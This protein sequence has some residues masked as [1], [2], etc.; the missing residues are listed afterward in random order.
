MVGMMV[1]VGVSGIA[2]FALY[3]AIAQVTNVQRVI[4]N[5]ETAK[6]T[7]DLISATLSSSVYCQKSFHNLN[8]R[9]LGDKNIDIPLI[10]RDL[11]DDLSLVGVRY[12]AGT[13][14]EPN[15]NLH[16]FQ[17]RKDMNLGNGNFLGSLTL[18][19]KDNTKG[20]GNVIAKEIPNSMNISAN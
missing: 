3:T 16:S 17:I 9:N 5:N 19:F 13:E 20:F 12:R 6:N 1:A 18:V 11:N 15:F 7:R 4:K 10:L 14:L 2:M 8:L